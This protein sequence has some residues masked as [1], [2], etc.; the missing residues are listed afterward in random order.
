M[1]SN[2]CGELCLGDSVEEVKYP[3]NVKSLAYTK[4]EENPNETDENVLAYAQ[5]LDN[6]IIVK[7]ACGSN[8]TFALSDKGQLYATGTFSNRN[9]H[10]TS[11]DND[12]NSG[13]TLEINK[14]STFM[15]YGPTSHLKIAD[16]AVRENHT[17]VLTTQGYLY[18]FGS[19][20]SYQLGRRISG[21]NKSNGLMPFPEKVAIRIKKIFA[22][23]Y[24]S[25]AVCDGGIT[26][27]WGQNAEG[28][29]G[30]HNTLV[31]LENGDVYSFGSTKYGQL[32]IGAS[33]GNRKFP[34]QI[35]LDKF[36]WRS[37]FYGC[38]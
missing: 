24:H 4:S 10:F 28:Q 15:K 31:L 27:V 9:L 26:Y 18:Y 34:V 35:N 37:S 29:C 22:G 8:I 7:V 36:D 33:E 32:G 11:K 12:G 25:F 30:L 13:F 2:D 23:G 14:Q 19:R 1:G 21:R 16:I 38:Q 6:I 17:S 20:D 3:R 5:G